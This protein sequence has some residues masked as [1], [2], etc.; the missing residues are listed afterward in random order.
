MPIMIIDEDNNMTIKYTNVAIIM[1]VTYT[2]LYRKVISVRNS[3]YSTIFYECKY[4]NYRRIKSLDFLSQSFK[5][6]GGMYFL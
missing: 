5:F 3:F 6:F 4:N 2:H 1:F